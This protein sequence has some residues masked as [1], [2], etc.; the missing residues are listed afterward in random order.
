MRVGALGKA[1]RVGYAEMVMGD[2]FYTELKILRLQTFL[3]M[4]D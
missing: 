4:L 3:I 1:S 2:G